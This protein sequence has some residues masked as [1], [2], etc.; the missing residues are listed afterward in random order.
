MASITLCCKKRLRPDGQKGSAI[1]A[2]RQVAVW[3]GLWLCL[4][5]FAAHAAADSASTDSPRVEVERVT[6][7][8]YL[9]A[10]LPFSL[11]EGMDEALHKG[12]PLHFVWQAEV[13]RPRWYWS[14]QKINSANRVVR[15]AYQPLTRRW[16]LSVSSGL[17]GDAGVVNALHQNVDTLQEALAIVTRVSNWKVAEGA[18][19]ASDTA[20]R[21]QLRFRLDA[22]LLPRTFQIGVPGRDDWRVDF[23]QVLNVPP[24]GEAQP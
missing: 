14:D 19:L 10:R 9:T 17:P 22:G 11:P 3:L 21:V 5:L 1:A 6:D 13:L 8:V 24:L 4:G 20:Y 12:V 16:R 18:A 7:G 2:L 15:L 23:L